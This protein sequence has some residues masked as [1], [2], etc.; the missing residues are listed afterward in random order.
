MISICLNT[1]ND[2]VATSSS[3]QTLNGTT[4]CRLPVLRGTNLS[5]WNDPSKSAPRVV[6]NGLAFSC[7]V[8]RIFG[9][10]R[11]RGNLV[12]NYRWLGLTLLLVP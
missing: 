7:A 1:L 8:A 5:R 9:I 4:G 2:T 10:G 6:S 3:S 12:V 11:S